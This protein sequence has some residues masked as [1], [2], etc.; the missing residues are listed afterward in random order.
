MKKETQ[1]DIERKEEHRKSI[2]FVQR[3][4]DDTVQ[5]YD[6]EF[7]VMS[8][9]LVKTGIATRSV[10]DKIEAEGHIKS[11]EIDVPSVLSPGRTVKEK[12]YYTERR[13]PRLVREM[14]ANKN[15]VN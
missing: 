11:V 14:T 1:N 13:I 5:A 12:A 10:L 6:D 15:D 8:Q 4:I 7:P 9:T 2:E 3:L